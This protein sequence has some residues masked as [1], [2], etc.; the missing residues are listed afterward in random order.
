MGYI[1]RKRFLKGYVGIY[2]HPAYLRVIP[3]IDL[4]FF[5]DSGQGFTLSWLIITIEIMFN[6]L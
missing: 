5:K 1:A 4:F 2:I 6:V 3:T